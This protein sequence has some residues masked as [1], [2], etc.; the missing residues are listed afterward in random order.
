MPLYTEATVSATGA[1]N[2]IPLNQYESPFNVGFGVTVIAPGVSAAVTPD[3]TV[4]HTFVDVLGG[5]SAGAGEIFDH[6]D[7]SGQSSSIDGNYAFPVAAV[8]LNVSALAT[9]GSVVFRV[10]QAGL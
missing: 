1:S 2:W 10:R 5:G 4:Q 6:P 3:F 7:A 8:R 9:A